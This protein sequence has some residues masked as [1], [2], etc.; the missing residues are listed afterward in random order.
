MQMHRQGFVSLLKSALAGIILLAAGAV[1]AQTFTLQNNEFSVTA[2]SGTS[3]ATQTQS[4]SEAGLVGTFTDL[5]ATDGFGIP[6]FDFTLVPNA[7]ADGDY[8]FRVGIT[9]DDDANSSRLEAK[10]ETLVLSVSGGTVTGSIPAASN[11]NG[12]YLLGRDSVNVFQLLIKVGNDQASGPIA[13]SGG[14]ISFNA[15]TLIER[16]KSATNDSF[17]TKILNAFNQTAS[18][19]YRIAV[20]QTSTTAAGNPTLQFGTTQS[21]FVA[22]PQVVSGTATGNDIQSA[23]AF[24]L[25]SS[26]L[27]VDFP[28]A[29]S[30]TGQFK[31]NIFDISADTN[32]LS[33]EIA[34]ISLP[35]SGEVPTATKTALYAAMTNAVTLLSNTEK[36]LKSG[37]LQTDAA[38]DAI[39]VVNTALAKI[40]SANISS[41]GDGVTP[42][43]ASIS[44]V[45][46]IAKVVGALPPSASTLTTSQKTQISTLATATASHVTSVLEEGISRS[47]VSGLVDVTSQLMQ[48]TLSSTGDLTQT[49]TDQLKALGTKAGSVYVATLPN[50]I[51][52]T[53]D[54]SELASILA[55]AD[56]SPTV[57]NTVLEASPVIAGGNTDNSEKT[58]STVRIT[59]GGTGKGLSGTLGAGTVLGGVLAATLVIS[60]DAGVD[61]AA[62]EIGGNDLSA[63]TATTAELVPNSMF[64]NLTAGDAVFAGLL[65]TVRVASDLLS[66]GESTL[67][68]GQKIA[69]K[70]GIAIEIGGAPANNTVFTQAIEGAGYTL[71]YVVGSN[72]SIGLPNNE[73]FSGTFPLQNVAASSECTS[74]SFTPASGALNAASY[75]FEMTCDNGVTQKI[76]PVV[77]DPAFYTTVADAGIEVSTDK[78]TGIVIIPGVGSFKPS[79]FVTPHSTV[80]TVDYNASKNADGI[81]FRASDKNGDGKIDYEILSIDGVQVLY[82]L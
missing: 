9:I 2:G 13:V 62:L 67:P 12:L 49:F 16:I 24:E 75:A 50:G 73:R 53:S 15:A 33:N 4:I 68:N 76:L 63:T 78:S 37:N 25:S 29:Y 21:S 31:V 5:P 26:E 35:S 43:T 42:V 74:V 45:A 38:L 46:N 27:S 56:T 11:P 8:H 36:E 66:E 7:V 23:T 72:F 82:S 41:S 28:S 55:L 22:L 18:Y 32:S 48:E 79:F 10:I 65:G 1:Q 14:K 57:K 54:L 71:D 61:A 3:A 59:G 81:A 52:K 69:V 44:A 60:V 19:T 30:V 51:T 47:R 40:T 64:I 6:S 39:A 58:S 20:Q 77:L 70:D 34:N 17:E 80:D